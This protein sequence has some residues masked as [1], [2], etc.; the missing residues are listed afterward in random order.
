MCVAKL[1]LV[2]TLTNCCCLG[3]IQFAK[4]TAGVASCHTKV[5]LQHAVIFDM[6]HTVAANRQRNLHSKLPVNATS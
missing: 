2:S 3:Y 4:I 6:Q 1:Q 5:Q